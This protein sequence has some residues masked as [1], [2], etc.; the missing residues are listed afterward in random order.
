MLPMPPMEP[1]SPTNVP[2]LPKVEL[3]VSLIVSTVPT[4]LLPLSVIVCVCVWPLVVSVKELLSVP[5]VCAVLSNTT[6][7]LTAVVVDVSAMLSGPV[8]TVAARCMPLSPTC[9][10]PLPTCVPPAA[11]VCVPRRISVPAP[12][13]FSVPAPVM[14]PLSVNVLPERRVDRV[15]RRQGAEVHRPEKRGGTREVGERA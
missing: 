15:E 1:V 11:V 10:V 3:P 7:E 12:C 6:A 4:A 8:P 14:L 13:L 2:L 9:R 5:T